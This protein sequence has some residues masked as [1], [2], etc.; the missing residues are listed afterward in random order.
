MPMDWL[1]R[2]TCEYNQNDVQMQ[3]YLAILHDL[4]ASNFKRKLQ[5]NETI[6]QDRRKS[7]SK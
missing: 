3:F 1:T 4:L 7:C 2:K 5:I 6:G